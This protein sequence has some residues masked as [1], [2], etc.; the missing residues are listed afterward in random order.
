MQYLNTEETTVCLKYILK[1]TFCYVLSSYYPDFIRH[2]RL[3]KAPVKTT[4]DT[5]VNLSNI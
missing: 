1:D 4:L 5:G 2:D 3:D